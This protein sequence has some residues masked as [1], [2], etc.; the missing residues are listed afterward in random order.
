MSIDSAF[1]DYQRTIN[2]DIKQVQVARQR[3]D[4]Y[5][6]AFRGESDVAEVFGSGAIARSTQLKPIHDLDMII[7]YK[8]EAYPGW[9]QPGDSS[10]DALQHVAAR[11]TALLG[12]AGLVASL[13]RLTHVDGRDRSVKCFV[14]PPE[15]DNAFTVDAMPALRLDDGT[16]LLP[17]VAR[18]RW[19]QADPEY[20]IEEVAKRQA[21]WDY[22]R[23]IVR[24]L[25]DWRLDIDVETKSL[26]ME[27]LALQCLPT[28]GSR[29]E[30]LRAFFT[31]AAVEVNYGV[32]DPA[33]YCG[34]IQPNL[35]L[36]ALSAALSDAGGAAVAACAAA[37]DGD[38]DE[39][40][41]HW[42]SL[43]GPDFPAPAKPKT[44]P[45]IVAPAFVR[46]RPVK[47]APQG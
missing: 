2:A 23:P 3:R 44:S 37:A 15:A 31:A 21:E 4:L 45:A 24:V 12:P 39:A 46:P 18:R 19:E 43:F 1:D 9:G 35:D 42:Q 40:L 13:V 7:V 34:P 10:L 29:A 6:K 25:K 16:L 47:D 11:T 38:T 5:K 8:A 33:D 22:Y 26:V 41:G 36:T 30:A 17:S 20:L 28:N 14:D 27:V 32:E